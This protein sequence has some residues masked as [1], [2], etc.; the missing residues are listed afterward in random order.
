MR[1]QVGLA[2]CAA[3]DMPDLRAAHSPPPFPT[4]PMFEPALPAGQC[5]VSAGSDPLLRIPFPKRNSGKRTPLEVLDCEQADPASAWFATHRLVTGR[6]HGLPRSATASTGSQRI[7]WRSRSAAA[8]TGSQ[9][10]LRSPD[11]RGC[12]DWLA[13]RT[14]R[15][16]EV[17]DCVD[18]L[19]ERT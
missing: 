19:A 13:E 8:S 2:T 9:Q 11:V 16:P 1:T 5:A 18:W 12:V 14:L 6:P 17:R 3:T 15:S 10:I 7:V 4:T